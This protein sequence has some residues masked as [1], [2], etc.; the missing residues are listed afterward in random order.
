MIV[1]VGPTGEDGVFDNIF[2]NRITNL[3][4]LIQFMSFMVISGMVILLDMIQ[5]LSML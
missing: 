5:S 2:D 4:R 3:N 1:V